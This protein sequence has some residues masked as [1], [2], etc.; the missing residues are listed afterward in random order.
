MC[1]RGTDEEVI[2]L[3]MQSTMTEILYQGKVQWGSMCLRDGGG[4]ILRMKVDILI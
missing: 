4:G 1:E 2:G 3:Y